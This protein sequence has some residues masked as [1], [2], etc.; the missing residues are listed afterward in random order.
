MNEVIANIGGPPVDALFKVLEDNQGSVPTVYFHHNEKDMQY[1]LHTLCG[2]IGS[3]GT[4]VLAMVPQQR[5]TP[6][7][8]IRRTFPRILLQ[9]PRREGAFA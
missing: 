7:R 8:A 3:D 5:A 6:I 4:A 1:A 9:P 2:S